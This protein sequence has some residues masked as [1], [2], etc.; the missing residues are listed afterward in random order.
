MILGR[1]NLCPTETESKI[2][3][4]CTNS[5]EKGYYKIK[6]CLS[7]SKSTGEGQLTIHI[8]HFGA[9]RSKSNFYSVFFTCRGTSLVLG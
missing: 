9:L 1:R 8:I 2:F 5:L 6:R 4:R 3:K 7:K